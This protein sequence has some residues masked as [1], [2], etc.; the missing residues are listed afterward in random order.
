M[1]KETYKVYL[2][3]KINEKFVGTESIESMKSNPLMRLPKRI[4]INSNLAGGMPETT[5]ITPQTDKPVQGM[6]FMSQPSGSQI[7]DDRMGVLNKNDP[8]ALQRGFASSTPTSEE[9]TEIDKNKAKTPP[10]KFN[11]RWLDA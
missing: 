5:P 7:Y 3:R 11:P 1:N 8:Y 2:Q 9:Q 4:G 6:G 10:I